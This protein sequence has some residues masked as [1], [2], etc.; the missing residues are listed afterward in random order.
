MY[1]Y[2]FAHNFLFGGVL[3]AVV[4]VVCN[5]PVDLQRTAKKYTKIYNARAQLLFSSLNLLFID[6]LVAVVVVVCLKLSVDYG[7]VHTK[8]IVNAN[9][10]KRIFLSPSTRKR[11]SFT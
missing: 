9:A 1:T 11:L 7:P 10:S 6:V 8:T 5:L 2:C 3:V 4:V